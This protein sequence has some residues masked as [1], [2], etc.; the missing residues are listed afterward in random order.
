MSSKYH[1]LLHDLPR[2]DDDTQ[3]PQEIVRFTW[4]RT[5]KIPLV[6]I[7]AVSFYTFGVCWVMTAV[8]QAPHLN[9]PLS[10]CKSKRFLAMF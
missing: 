6:M 9:F 10:S 3:P 7:A 8:I 4:L 5:L 2:D 1:P